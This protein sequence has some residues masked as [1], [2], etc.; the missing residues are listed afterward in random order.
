[1][2]KTIK[3][4]STI[5]RSTEPMAAQFVQRVQERFKEPVSPAQ[6]LAAM[7]KISI[8]T[9]TLEKVVTKVQ[10]LQKKEQRKAQRQRARRQK[11]HATAPRPRADASSVSGQS[12]LSTPMA[13]GATLPKT[14]LEKLQA[15]LEE[16]WDR[17]EAEG[18]NPKRM[19][20]EGF[21]NAVYGYT[22]RREASRRRI[23]QA[24]KQLDQ[25]DVLL[26]PALVADVV[27]E[28]FQNG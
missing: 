12:I 4:I 13:S 19:S 1:M 20:A 18:L 10:E 7:Q 25:S 5:L 21:M 6:V 14:I 17:A 11:S 8:K 9:L 24:A 26:T 15:V 16:N 27:H 22:D 3:E 28:L 23:L 2:E